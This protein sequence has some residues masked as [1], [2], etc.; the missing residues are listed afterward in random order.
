MTIGTKD[1]YGDKAAAK[2]RRLIKV[3]RNSVASGAKITEGD[4]VEVSDR[5]A[6]LLVALKKA[7]YATDEATPAVEPEST[8]AEGATAKKNK[9]KK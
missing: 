9:S 6:R 4:V 1:F 3:L 5:D 2:G 7:E 8:T